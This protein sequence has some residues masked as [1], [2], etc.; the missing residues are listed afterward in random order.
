MS[1]PPHRSHM[2]AFLKNIILG[3]PVKDRVGEAQEPA[4]ESAVPPVAP[5]PARPAV[6]GLP[7]RPQPRTHA[8]GNGNSV[9]VSLQ[10]VLGAFPLELKGRIRQSDVGE[11]T[12]SIPMRSEEHTSELQ[13]PMY[14]VCR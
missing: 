9:E 1:A 5:A 6:N 2:F 10:N 14:L 3:K 12:V 11:A 4:P 13:S 7:L 8:N